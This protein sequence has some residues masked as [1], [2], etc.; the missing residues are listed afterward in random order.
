MNEQE[1]FKKI[2]Q[3]ITPD[4]IKH[5]GAV[6][7][8]IVKGSGEDKTFHIDLKNTGKLG[9]G[10]AEKVDVTFEM[11]DE[12]FIPILTGQLSSMTAFVTQ[13]LKIKGDLT[14]AMKLETLIKNIGKK[15][16]N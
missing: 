5:A 12:D 8:F 16:L 11:N 4:A 2:Q 10:L 6:F 14:K 7:N 15:I 9:M 13:K 3:A 1:L